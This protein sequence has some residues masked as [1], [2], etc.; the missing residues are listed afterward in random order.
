MEQS[1]TD[2][3]SDIYYFTGSAYTCAFDNPAS[4]GNKLYKA[5]KD[6]RQMGNV[7]LWLCAVFDL[8]LFYD[9]ASVALRGI[10]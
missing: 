5:K 7:Y 6:Q 4:Y 3:K 10:F 8:R 2:D 1:D 9:D